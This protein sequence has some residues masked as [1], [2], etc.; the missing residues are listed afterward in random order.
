M[1]YILSYWLCPF[2]IRRTVFLRTFPSSSSLLWKTHR[3]PITRLAESMGTSSQTLFCSNSFNFSYIARDQC[4]PTM[5]LLILIGSIFGEKAIR[6]HTLL[7]DCWMVTPLDISPMTFWI[8][9]SFVILHSFGRSG[10]SYGV[11]GIFS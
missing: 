4:S 3:I 8:G 2:V 6:L 9:W 11:S 5:V 10:S 7:R 1:K